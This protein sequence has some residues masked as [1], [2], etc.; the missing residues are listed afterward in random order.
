[1][2]SFLLTVGDDEY[3][4]KANTQ[5]KIEAEKKLGMSL[6][7]AQVRIDEA[8]VFAVV[9]W[10]ALQSLNHGMSMKDTYDLIDDMEDKGCKYIDPVE[11]KEV[12]IDSM[13]ISEK[14]GLSA[15]ILT[16][17]GF[18]TKA[19]IEEMREHKEEEKPRTPRKKKSTPPQQN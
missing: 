15:A 10:A 16:V 7:R 3:R 11:D 4:L 13:G 8:E 14:Q 19:E 18:F 2:N 9:L 17:S 12:T 5:S 6:L 1:M